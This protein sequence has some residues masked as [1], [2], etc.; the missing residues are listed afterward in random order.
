MFSL[1]LTSES[2]TLTFLPTTLLTCLLIP[3]SS[4]PCA[5][6]PSRLCSVLNPLQLS[7]HLILLATPT[8]GDTVPVSQSHPFPSLLSIHFSS[9]FPAPQPMWDHCTMDFLGSLPRALLSS[10]S[11]RNFI[12]Y[13]NIR[14]LMTPNLYVQRIPLCGA[15]NQY[16]HS[17]PGTSIWVCPWT[18]KR[19]L[20]K[21]EHTVA[22]TSVPWT[23]APSPPPGGSRGDCPPDSSLPPP[24][25][26]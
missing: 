2:L 24:L 17:S 22:S 12:H 15:P 20:S 25:T 13:M 11:Q 9:S 23:M 18:L 3:S 21:T 10:L 7:T 6:K 1:P 19:T 26:H 16:L 14:G 4:E 8:F 5:L